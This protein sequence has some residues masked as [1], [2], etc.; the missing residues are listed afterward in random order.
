[1]RTKKRVILVL[2]LIMMIFWIGVVSSIFI[3]AQNPH[4]H[5][6]IPSIRLMDFYSDTAL[7]EITVLSGGQHDYAFK[8]LFQADLPAGHSA[9]FTAH[10][11]FET[12]LIFSSIQ[13]DGVCSFTGLESQRSTVYNHVWNISANI[14]LTGDGGYLNFVFAST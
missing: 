11:K 8:L 13:T 1:M 7:G 10:L 5:V 3:N 12:T 9:T 6:T 14:T 2:A 4:S